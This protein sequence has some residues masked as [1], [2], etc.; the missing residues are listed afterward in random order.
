MIVSLSQ[1]YGSS[2][3][4]RIYF[5]ILD[6]QISLS[7]DGSGAPWN[8]TQIGIWANKGQLIAVQ[9][10]QFIPGVDTTRVEVV[11]FHQAYLVK[12]DLSGFILCQRK[13]E[14]GTLISTLE[15][16]ALSVVVK[17]RHEAIRL[18]ENAPFDQ[19][20]ERLMEGKT[21]VLQLVGLH[22]G[23]AIVQLGDEKAPETGLIELV[24]VPR[25]VLFR[26]LKQQP[27]PNGQGRGSS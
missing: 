27:L 13:S 14:N 24:M 10:S 18:P 22:A 20:A 5:V 11:S 2:D 19:T 1:L 7:E 26:P 21:T 3:R 15:G 12:P 17:R 16:E 9:N 6:Q 8:S 23:E 25:G 4:S